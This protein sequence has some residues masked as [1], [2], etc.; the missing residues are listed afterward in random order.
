MGELGEATSP[1][2]V[3]SPLVGAEVDLATGGDTRLPLIQDWEYAALVLSGTVEVDGLP[4]TTG[5]LLYLGT[6][7][8][9]LRL[10]SD[11][12]GRV[13]LIGGGPFGE[14]LVMWWNFIGR[15]HDDIVAAREDWMSGQR[16]GTVR[17][18]AGDPLPAPPMPT[19][20]L[21]SRGRQR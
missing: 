19:T 15:D 16:F 9:D 21:K 3:F 14:Q 1:A 11:E 2:R 4:L 6:G 12:P 8:S 10:H 20:R 17:G 7:R 18:Y 5:P 13:L